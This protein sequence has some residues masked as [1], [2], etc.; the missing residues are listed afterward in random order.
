MSH[1]RAAGRA[2]SGRRD[3]HHTDMNPAIGELAAAIVFLAS[4]AASY[5]TGT[6]LDVDGG[7][8]A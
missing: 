7:Y 2:T 1:T 3:Y 6:T 5:I 8:N 4:P